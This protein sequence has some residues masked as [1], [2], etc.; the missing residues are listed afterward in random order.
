MPRPTTAPRPAVAYAELHA[1]STFSLL[2]G[3]SDPEALVARARE[4]GLAALALT[5]HDDV[6]GAVRFATATREAGLPGILGAELTVDVPLP[7]GLAPAVRDALPGRVGGRIRSR[8]SA[9]I[10]CVSWRAVRDGGIS[11]P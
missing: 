7:T 10:W 11:A 3:A 4:L 9:R 2:D 6:G 5:D 1:H 8:G